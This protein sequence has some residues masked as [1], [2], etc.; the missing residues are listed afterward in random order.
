[1]QSHWIA[2]REV[3][4]GRTTGGVVKIE[5]ADELGYASAVGFGHAMDRP[6]Q[7]WLT[8]LIAQGRLAEC[9]KDDPATLAI[10]IVMRKLGFWHAA[11]ED[12]GRLAP[13]L[14]LVIDAYAAGVNAGLAAHGVPFELKLVKYRP[15]PWVAADSLMI[16]A[17]MGY[18]GLAQTQ[19]DIE[20]FILQAIKGGV[21]LA[22]L[23]TLFSPHLDD[24]SEA[25]LAAIGKLTIAEAI[26]PDALTLFPGLRASNNW[27]VSPARSA[28]GKAIY[29]S[30]PH[31]EINRLPA[32]WSEIVARV[33]DDWRIGITVPGTPAMVMG[34][35][36][37]VAFG[38]TYGFMD[39][40]D[41]FIEEVRGGA[42]RRGEDFEPV[43]T[44]LETIYRKGRGKVEIEVHASRHGVIEHGDGALRDGFFLARAWSG[45]QGGAAAT[46]AALQGLAQARNVEEARVAAS[47]AA[48]SANWVI[49]DE[50]GHIAHQQSGWSPRRRVSG[51][52]PMLGWDAADDWRGR[53]DPSELA[54]IVDPP[55]GFLASAN[56]PRGKVGVNL[57]MG[58][59]R[60]D[61][62]EALIRAK[63]KLD[64][65]DMRALQTD[66]LSLQ[67]EAWLA[68]FLPLM[69]DGPC[70][71]ALIEWDRRYDPASRGAVLFER[72][73]EA[74]LEETMGKRVFGLEAW[75]T[76]WRETCL[77][78]TYFDLFDRALL[79]DEALWYAPDGKAAVVAAA[80]ARAFDGVEPSLSPSWGERRQF[81]FTNVFFNG[82]LPGFAGFDRGPFALPGGRATIAQGQL[83]KSYGRATSF[84]PSWR[85][86]AD[87]A[88]K[89]VET[90]LPGGP[91]DRRFSAH[92]A[93]D[94]ANWLAGKTKR[95]S[96]D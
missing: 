71:T 75:R 46:F 69:P 5:A 39:Q 32:I 24:L 19:Q 92:Y 28:S 68:H 59:A 15:E 53:L 89:A 35:T 37:R 79:S 4:I 9:L 44:R 88:E 60:L 85:L 27:A 45:E 31:L 50:A 64:V 20:K 61:R 84:A 49:A 30:D 7:L 11:R 1:M 29:C 73:Y 26:A 41:Y 34:R 17:L 22:K 38:L 42:C 33:G 87:F 81:K 62:I 82:A 93:T 80:A 95:L 6:L 48:M 66:V 16:G 70:K 10:D 67:A 54:S 83:F 18:I 57:A 3:K 14:R 36:S 58:S 63:D 25:R 13:E 77:P 47:K 43:T 65:A 40:I 55:E 74:L 91:S 96:P 94:I 72:F 76:L 12:A 78:H 23:K 51:L 56:D 21:D 90:A 52:V 86:I 2:G 8:R